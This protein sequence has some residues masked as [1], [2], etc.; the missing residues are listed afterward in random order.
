MAKPAPV[1]LIVDDDAVT[2]HDFSRMLVLSGYRVRTAGSSDEALGQDPHDPP[3]AMLLDLRMPHLDGLKLLERLRERPGWQT[4]PAAIIT[5]DYFVEDAV[6]Q[7]LRASHTQV[8]FKPLWLEDLVKLVA[9]LVGG[10]G[11]GR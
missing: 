8:R 6:I 1:I 11:R 5:G 4:I 2:V 3:D 10:S 9:E 7:A